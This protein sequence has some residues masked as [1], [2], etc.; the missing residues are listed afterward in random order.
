MNIVI[1]Q[2]MLFPWVGMLEQIKLA[3]CYVYYDDVPFSKGSFVN[4]V[5]I[6]TQNGPRWMTIPLMNRN[7]GQKIDEIEIIKTSQ[8]RDKNMILLKNSFNGAKYANDAL[9]IASNIYSFNYKNIGELAR[10]SLMSLVSYFSLDKQM[11]F[12][13]VKELNIGGSSSK[14]VLDVVR[15]LGGDHYITGLGALKYLDHNLFETNG[16]NVE[17]MQYRYCAYPQLHGEF[18]PFVSGLDLVANCGTEGIS[19]ICSKSIN[20]RSFTNEH[21]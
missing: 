9:D 10:A 21:F 4:R 17:Y 13:D 2:S 12:I 3:D 1:S 15:K 14:R 5:Q 6:K 19:Y 11:K 20:W 7:L 18:T 8:W 16:I